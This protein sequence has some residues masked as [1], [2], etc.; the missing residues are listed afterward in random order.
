ML[1]FVSSGYEVLGLIPSHANACYIYISTVYGPQQERDVVRE[2]IIYLFIYFL[3]QSIQR[4]SPETDQFILADT[5]QRKGG[6]HRVA[7]RSLGS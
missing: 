1:E 7:L 2:L 4:Q 6:A 3:R 5:C